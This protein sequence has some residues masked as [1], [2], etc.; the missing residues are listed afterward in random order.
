LLSRSASRR[1]TPHLTYTGGDNKQERGEHGLAA[2]PL[3]A[4]G[5]L[6]KL[7]RLLAA[8]EPSAVRALVIS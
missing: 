1:K 7:Q 6:F 2:G 5:G 4:D 3:S 8:V